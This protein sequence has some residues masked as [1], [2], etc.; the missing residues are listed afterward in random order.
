MPSDKNVSPNAQLLQIPPLLSVQ[1]AETPEKMKLGSLFLK[2][3]MISKNI[4]IQGTPFLIVSIRHAVVA[5]RPLIAVWCIG[6][7]VVSVGLLR[8]RHAAQ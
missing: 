4:L 8:L 2:A 1:V 6:W 3:V 7:R 5:G